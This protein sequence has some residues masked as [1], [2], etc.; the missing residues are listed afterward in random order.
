MGG[1]CEKS[2][3]IQLDTF[4]PTSRREYD[5]LDEDITVIKEKP[6]LP[7]FAECRDVDDLLADYQF[8]MQ[9][10]LYGET[11]KQRKPIADVR[12]QIEQQ[13]DPEG[14]LVDDI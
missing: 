2:K 3:R 1:A 14:H 13:A 4:G 5:I 8:H 12:A 9:E 10:T 7:Q 6:E 11:Q